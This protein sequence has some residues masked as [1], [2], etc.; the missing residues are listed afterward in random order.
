MLA[1]R[2]IEWGIRIV[3]WGV[4]IGAVLLISA[5]LTA[6]VVWGGEELIRKKRGSFLPRFVIVL[7]LVCVLLAVLAL[8]PP[9]IC[10]ERYEPYLTPERRDAVQSGVNGVYNWN[11]PLVPVC[12]RITGINN[13]VKDGSMEYCLEYIVYYFC[14]GS[15]RMEYSTYDGYNS[16]PM[17]GG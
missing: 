16:Y 11:I 4:Q 14:L 13:F 17:F 3:A 1:D 10:P 6:V 9:V 7:L 12:V 2:I 5:V 15:M 8:D